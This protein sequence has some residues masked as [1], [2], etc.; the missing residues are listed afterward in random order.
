M[1]AS[2][3]EPIAVAEEHL[4]RLLRRQAATV[5]VVTATDGGRPVGFTATSF[6]SVSMHPPLVSFCVSRR[7]SFWLVLQATEHV[8]VHLLD[9]GQAELARTFAT[10]G[11]DRF[12]AVGWLPG[13]CGVPLLKRT[14]GWLVGRIA[15]RV[16]A[17]DHAIVLAEP[18]TIGWVEGSPPLYHNG[19]YTGLYG[20]YT[21]LR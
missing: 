18:V 4:R 19:Q 15:A 3:T 14:L 17:G 8:A 9:A 20:Q 6:T 1:T 7:S 5:T 11:I 16:I 21:G 10:R 12:A 13:P 2:S